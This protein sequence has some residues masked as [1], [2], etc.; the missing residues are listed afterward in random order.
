[1]NFWTQ[2]TGNKGMNTYI[3][4]DNN[5]TTTIIGSNFKDPSNG[6]HRPAS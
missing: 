4:Y 6:P 5:E 2:K 3:L 1:M